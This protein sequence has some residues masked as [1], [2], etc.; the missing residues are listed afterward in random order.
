MG[1]QT[2]RETLGDKVAG[3]AK[4]NAVEG[5]LGVVRTKLTAAQVKALAASPAV[6]LAA[7]GA[8]KV[9]LFVGGHARLIY[10]GNNVF[11]E[12]GGGSNLGIKYTDGS[13]VQVSGDIEATDFIDQAADTYTSIPAA[14][15]AIVA[16]TGAENQALVLHN[17]GAGEI[18]GNLADDNEVEVFMAYRTVEL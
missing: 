6:L 17:I 1:E 5:F 3:L 8:G 15:D 13:G 4:Y 7:P 12:D 16:A 2:V 9:H 10:G 18:V 11:A 14:A